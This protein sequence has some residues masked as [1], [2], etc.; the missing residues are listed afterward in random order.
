MSSRSDSLGAP[1]VVSDPGCLTP[2]AAIEFVEGRCPPEQVGTVGRHVDGC[3]LCR[4]LLAAL[5]LDEDLA[6]PV[7]AREPAGVTEPRASAEERLLE[8]RLERGRSVGRYLLLN[9]LGVGGMGVVYSAYDPELD[10]KVALKLLRVSTAHTRESQ[11]RLLREAQAMARLQHP[12]VLAVFDAGTFGDEVFIAMELVEGSTLTRWLGT[13]RRAWREV[14]A[15]FLDAGRGLAAAHVAGL[16]HRDFKPDN[17]LMSRDG[18]ARVTDFG[19]ATAFGAGEAAAPPASGLVASSGE[20]RLTRTGTMLGTPAYMAPEQ[21]AGG[22]VDARTDQFSFCVSLYEALHG[23]RPFAGETWEALRGNV[24][25]HKVRPPPRGARV[26]PWL[27]R[28]LLRGL[29][30]RPEARFASMEVLLTELRRAPQAILRRRVAVAVLLA[31]VGVGGL[32]LRELRQRRARCQGVAAR[33]E[34]VWDEARRKRVSETFLATGQPYARDAWHMVERA[35]DDYSARWARDWTEACEA[36]WVARRQPEEAL[37]RQHQCLE[38]SRG[39]VQAVTELLA[40]ASAAE[41]REAANLMATLPDLNACAGQAPGPSATPPAGTPESSPEKDALRLRL[42]RVEALQAARREREGLELA[43]AVYT[44]ARALKD[45]PLEAETLLRQGQLQQA[46]QENPEAERLLTEAVLT[47]EALGLDELKARAQLELV[48]LY[49]VN[50]HQ[51]GP[52]VAWSRQAQASIHRLG[53][54]LRLQ[55]PL[56][57]HLGGALF[58]A[59]RYAEAAEHFEEARRQ[60]A[61]VLGEDHPRLAGIWANAGMGLSALG[62]YE[63]ATVAVRHALALAVKWLGPRHPRV[64]HIQTNLVQLLLYQHREDEALPVS[65]EAVAIYSSL[66][67]EPP[68]AARSWL[69][70]GHIHLER[71]EH[72]PSR[73]ALEHALAIARRVYGPEAPE[74]ADALTGLGEL[75]SAEGRHEEALASMRRALELQQQALGPSHLALAETLVRMGQVQLALRH[76]PRAT[77]SFERVL[78]LQEVEQNEPIVAEARLALARLMERR[79]DQRAQAVEHARRALAFYTRHP[80]DAAE[81]AELEALLGRLTSGED[82]RRR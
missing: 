74:L 44:R 6:P 58:D 31:V 57:L 22:A 64:A 4:R 36:T 66:D 38:W 82:S 49:G 54:A 53:G 61:E 43:Q 47:A 12:H 10:R 68:G 8:A 50:L 52:A 2:D 78:R 67:E 46:L 62:R 17:I 7:P 3:A 65:Q 73:R 76:T 30:P 41:V 5:A 37:R 24:L 28:V 1:P 56:H 77:A 18:R 20:P 14:L 40:Q 48:W 80:W 9:R 63:E 26:P 23:E 69:F 34:G 32:V 72:A 59:G 75:L 55:Y 25:D 21:L 71:G 60:A 70:L 35:L 39:K 16:V 79:V 19:L 29:S 11:A 15:V 27:R 42:A 51:V 81:K 13:E 45:G 33:L